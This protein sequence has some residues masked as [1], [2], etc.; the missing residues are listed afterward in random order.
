MN[1]VARSNIL[2]Y[3]FSF[4]LKIQYLVIVNKFFLTFSDSNNLWLKKEFTQRNIIIKHNWVYIAR[5]AIS[6]IKYLDLYLFFYFSSLV[7]IYY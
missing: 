4:I 2:I 3:I 7:F 5:V 1:H 6:N